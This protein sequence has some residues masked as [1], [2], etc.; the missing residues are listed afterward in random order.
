MYAGNNVD[1][2]EMSEMKKVLV[3]LAT[4]AVGSITLYSV[5]VASPCEVKG[6]ALGHI[7][8]GVVKCDHQHL[9]SLIVNGPVTLN[10]GSYGDVRIH[11]SLSSNQVDFN[12]VVD[13]KGPATFDHDRFKSKVN[14][15]G[16][17]KCKSS[18]FDRN[19]QLVSDYSVFN[20]CNMQS[21]VMSNHG[22]MKESKLYVKDNSMVNGDITFKNKAG[23]VYLSADSHIFGHV[24]N[25]IIKIVS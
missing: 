14:I 4:V 25:G 3:A 13:V 23:V 15:T 6:I 24:N 18:R 22:K 11:G 1:H 20:A 21:I 17:I 16:E 10:G 5:A 7:M 2:R 8:S 19:I 12:Q 9:S